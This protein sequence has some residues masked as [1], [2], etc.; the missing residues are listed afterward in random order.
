MDAF[1]SNPTRFQKQVNEGEFARVLANLT[2]NSSEKNSFNLMLR[3]VI[4]DLKDWS[5]DTFGNQDYVLLETSGGI[6]HIASLT[7]DGVINAFR[8]VAHLYKQSDRILCIDEPCLSL[9]PHSVKRLANILIDVAKD[10]QIIIATHSP[11]FINWKAINNGGNVI[12]FAKSKNASY[13]KAYELV[14]SSPHFKKFMKVGQ[15]GLNRHLVDIAAKTTL[16]SQ[17]VIFVEGKDDA[18][19]IKHFIEEECLDYNFDIFGFVAGGAGNI[20][21]FLAFAKDMGIASGALYD[22]NKSADATNAAATYTESIIKTLPVDDIR[23]KGTPN[24]GFFSDTGIIHS[25]RKKE[26][27]NILDDFHNH[28]N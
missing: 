19:L 10:R 20:K 28:F 24:S 16:F 8:L 21:D 17:N 11:Y 15:N 25:N 12:R 3:K 7:G 13:S 2:K 23:D 4:P 5:I 27:I 22:G 26:L 9:H 18:G 6:K 1:R 14:N